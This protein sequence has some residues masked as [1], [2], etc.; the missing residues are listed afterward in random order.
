MKAGLLPRLANHVIVVYLEATP[1]ETEARLLH[2]LR[3]RCPGLPENIN[4]TQTL[5]ELRRGETIPS[6][7]EGPDCPGSV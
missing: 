4:L 3:K 7:K 1:D 2:G 5:A 6:G